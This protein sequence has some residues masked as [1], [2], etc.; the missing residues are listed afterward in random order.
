MIVLSIFVSLNFISVIDSINSS[1]SKLL[2]FEILDYSNLF[3]QRPGLP[4]GLE[5]VQNISIRCNVVAW[6][7][8]I[9]INLETS[10]FKPL[11]YDHN[12][13]ILIKSEVFLIN[14]N[15]FC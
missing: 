9:F 13:L 4:G 12:Y 11:S 3:F 2:D 10:G 8:K 1:V 14:V 5:F 7:F 6:S 15:Q